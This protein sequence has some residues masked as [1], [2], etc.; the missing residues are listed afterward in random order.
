LLGHFSDNELP[1]RKDALDRYLALPEKDPG[2]T[3]AETWLTS[4]PGGRSRAIGDADREAFLTMVVDRYFRI[5]TQ[6]IRK[7]DP[8]HLCLGSRFHGGVLS[9]PEVFRA[10]G[11]H[12]DVVSV[13]YYNTWT[14]DFDRMRGWEQAAGR[15]FIVTDWYVK[16]MDSGMPNTTGAGWEVRTQRDRGLFYQNFALALL[17]SRSCVGWHW[18]KYMDNDPDD[19]TNRP[20]EPR[21]EQGHRELQVRAVRAADRGDAAAQPAC[22]RPGGLVR[23]AAA[24]TLA[25]REVR[26]RRPSALRRAERAA[27]RRRS[28]APRAGPRSCSS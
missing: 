17:E 1:F 9:M 24:R 23:R 21:L 13:N 10:A 22:V 4:R 11:R 26:T 28:P 12:L 5:T 16:G 27:A 6:A 14:P 20:V 2:R 3:A 7:Y 19:Q 15:P 25:R 18:F 8:N